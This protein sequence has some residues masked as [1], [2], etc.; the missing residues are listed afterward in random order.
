MDL[1]VDTVKSIEFN[2][3][4]EEVEKFR[5]ASKHLYSE[6]RKLELVEILKDPK[7]VW[8]C[9]IALSSFMYN[10]FYEQIVQV[11]SGVPS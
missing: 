5:K 3:L 6:K 1:V 10:L 11:I 9:K 7:S 4:K 8:G 2:L